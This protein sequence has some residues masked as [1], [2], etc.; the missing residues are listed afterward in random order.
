MQIRAATQADH[1]GIRAVN[2]AAFARDDEANL[3]DKLRAS[4][5]VAA[6]FVAVDQARVIGHVLYSRAVMENGTPEGVRAVALGP[7]AVRPGSQSTGI[8][9]QLIRESLKAI[10]AQGVQAAVIL[11]HEGYYQR[12]GF[13]PEAARPLQSPYAVH[14][15]SFMARE[16]A[17]GALKGATKV[18]Y[19][20]AFA[21]LDAGPQPVAHAAPRSAKIQPGG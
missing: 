1:A 21:E 12:F 14:G 20:A 5:N 2:V 9:S 17:P 13:S 10:Q 7:A 6:E 16:L 11:G 4:G 15:D 19:P 3:I 18:T 8:G